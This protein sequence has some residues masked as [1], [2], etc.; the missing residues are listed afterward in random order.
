MAYIVCHAEKQSALLSMPHHI[1]RIGFYNKDGSVVTEKDPENPGK[2]RLKFPQIKHPEWH[3]WNRG[4]GASYADFGKAWREAIAGLER[5][6]QKNASPTV[7]FNIS[8][9][10]DFFKGLREQ[11]PRDEDYFAKCEEYFEQCRKVLDELYPY[12]KT[13]KWATHYE[14]TTPHMHVLKIPLVMAK[15]RQ[16]EKAK[17]AGKAPGPKV[18]KFASGEFLG[19]QSGL[20]TLHDTLFEQVGKTWDLERGERGSDAHHTDQAEWQRELARKEK[21]IETDRQEIINAANVQA[22]SILQEAE[23]KKA[24][25]DEREKTMDEA[26]N[27]KLTGWDFPGY[28][29]KEHKKIP[30]LGDVFSMDYLNRVYDWVAGFVDKVKSLITENESTKKELSK[31]LKE[32]VS[33]NTKISYALDRLDGKYGDAKQYEHWKALRDQET[34]GK[35]KG[36]DGGISSQ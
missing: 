17:K 11:Y 1:E 35:E 22:A 14:E 12:G 7:C 25:L 15:K 19:G 24:A 23:Q 33:L 32:Q 28:L 20:S 10:E 13:L 29:P 6:P 36:K 21:Q 27:T 5:K 8:A 4:G 34:K 31:K 2:K 16:S 26:R 18:L 30:L 3:K 9:G